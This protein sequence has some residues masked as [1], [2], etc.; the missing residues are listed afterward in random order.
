MSILPALFFDKC[1]KAKEYFGDD[2]PSPNHYILQVAA[3][4]KD[5]QMVKEFIKYLITE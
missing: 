1:P 2:Y 5:K 4:S 3:G